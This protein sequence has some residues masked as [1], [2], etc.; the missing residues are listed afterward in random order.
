MGAGA[1]AEAEALEPVGRLCLVSRRGFVA[2]LG[3]GS[4]SR[5]EEGG[6]K[7]KGPRGYSVAEAEIKIP[8]WDISPWIG[9]RIPVNARPLDSGG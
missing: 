9:V 2:A 3:L 7:R 6:K 1:G 4:V 5:E 8:V